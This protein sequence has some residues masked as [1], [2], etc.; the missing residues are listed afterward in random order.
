MSYPFLN[1][2]RW[3][4][5]FRLQYKKTGYLQEVSL[6]NFC[7]FFKVVICVDVELHRYE[8]S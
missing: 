8:N 7:L 2:A 1:A 4:T 5:W 3:L 6:S